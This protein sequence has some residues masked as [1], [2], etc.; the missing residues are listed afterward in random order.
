MS[1]YDS[2]G[3]ITGQTH[4]FSL[5]GSVYSMWTIQEWTYSAHTWSQNLHTYLESELTYIHEVRTYIHTWSLNLHTYM[6]FELTYILGVWTYIHTWSS[7]LHTHME[8][9]LTYIHGV[10]TYIHTWSFYLQGVL[11]YPC[12]LM[13]EL[14]QTGMHHRSTPIFN[15]IILRWQ[16][17]AATMHTACFYPWSF[18]RSNCYFSCLATPCT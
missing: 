9:E 3:V 7:N 6:E 1:L 17:V 5:C 10:W 4:W 8:S 16:C 11:T 14:S 18:I 15:S 2:C 12:W 13:V